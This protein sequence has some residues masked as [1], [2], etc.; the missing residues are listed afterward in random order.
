M[1]IKTSVYDLKQN[2]FTEINKNWMLI[3]AAKPDGSINTMTASW[4]AMGEIWNREAVTVYIRQSRYTKEFVDAQDL[5]TV[6]LFE[7]HKKELGYLGTASGRDGDKIAAAGLHPVMLEGQPG[8]EE[9][10]CVLVCRK[11]YQDDIRMEDMPEDVRAKFYADG[12]FHTMY[13]GEIIA[14]YVNR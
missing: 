11:I 6:S 5:F 4:G 10:K 9:S 8:F 2:V 14:C 3:T 7:G 12:D 13:I 1:F